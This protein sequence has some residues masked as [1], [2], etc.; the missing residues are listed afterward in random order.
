MAGV[1]TSP[2]EDRGLRAGCGVHR[3]KIGDYEQA[4]EFTARSA[5]FWRQRGPGRNINAHSAFEELGLLQVRLGR[6]AEARASA[7]EAVAVLREHAETDGDQLSLDDLAGGLHNHANRLRD[8]GHFEEAVEAAQESVDRYRALLAGTEHPARV[9]RAELRL[10]VALVSLGSRLHN[11]GRL[12]ESLA[13]SDEALALATKHEDRELGR[14]ELARAWNNRAGL[15]IAR[16]SHA[17]AQEAA[18]LG[19]ELNQTDDGKALAR[20]TFALAAAHAGSLDAALEASS[21]AVTHYRERHAENPYEHGYLLADALTDHAV[22]RTLR[23]ERTEASVA[24]TE[25]LAMLEEL[26]AHNPARYQ[27]ELDH[28]REVAGRI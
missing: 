11:V 14:R 22:V 8:L 27:R 24:I 19:I 21:L 16:G 23:S 2:R 5:A 10:S 9:M 28:A 12:D 20:N 13:A 17:E 15:L 25:A 7:D 6:L 4:A 1:R 26:A 3:A 18:A